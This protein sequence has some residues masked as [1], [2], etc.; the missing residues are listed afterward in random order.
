MNQ[1]REALTKAVGEGKLDKDV[2]PR[3]KKNSKPKRQGKRSTGE[4]TLRA[5]RLLLLAEAMR[6]DK[7]EEIPESIRD[8]LFESLVI[9]AGEVSERIDEYESEREAQEKIR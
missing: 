8:S 9:M 5:V 6:H 2:L 7:G 1:M 3:G 4:V